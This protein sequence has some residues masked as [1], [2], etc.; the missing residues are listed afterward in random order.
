MASLRD[1]NLALFPSLRTLV[2]DVVPENA[3]DA[4][5]VIV[6]NGILAILR[7]I[8]P[9]TQIQHLRL[10]SPVWQS[11]IH[12][13]WAQSTLVRALQR[14]L[15]SVDRCL[16]FLVDRA[17]LQ[18]ITLVPPPGERFSSVEWV[19][20]ESLF[21][22]LRSYGMLEHQVRLSASPRSQLSC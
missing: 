13:G 15:Y 8:P 4:Q 19:R 3:G 16:A 18:V 1:F 20:V 12:S 14:P 17:P 10:S 22:A 6:W 7:S 5:L 2:I 21:E 9:A 11:V